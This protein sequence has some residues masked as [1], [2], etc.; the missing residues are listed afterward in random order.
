MLFRSYGY[1]GPDWLD[2]G[3]GNDLIEAG[4]G[5]DTLIAGGGQDT[6][7]GGN[8][9]DLYRI[10]RSGS[11]ILI[12]D[13][14]SSSNDPNADV[15]EFS[16]L[17]SVELSG[18]ERLGTDLILRFAASGDQLRVMNQ[19]MNPSTSIEAFRFADGVV[20]TQA[21]ILDRLATPLSP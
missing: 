5:N 2:G 14:E 13:Y 10:S 20:W 8:G 1:G 21:T 12:Y 9:N 11:S 17:G 18:V 16:D 7:Y 3:S 19:F 6:L 15:V 4:I